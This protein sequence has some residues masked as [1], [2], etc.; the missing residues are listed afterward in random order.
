M[1]RIVCLLAAIQS[2]A[3]APA[4]LVD[5]RNAGDPI[6]R[7]E[8][9]ASVDKESTTLSGEVKLTITI[10]ATGPLSVT[11]PKPLVTKPNLWRVR[12]DSPPLR[13]VADGREKWIQ[14]YRLSPLVRGKTELPLGTFQ[15]QAGGEKEMTI[16]WN[17]QSLFVD[18]GVLKSI[19]PY[20]ASPSAEALRKAADIEQLPPPP[21]I[22]PDSSPWLFAIVPILLLVA[23]VGVYLGRRKRTPPVPRDAVWARNE[24]AHPNLTAD[25][26]AVVMR[27]YLAYRFG[28][29]AEARTTPELA[30]TLQ[31]DGRMSI[32][33]VHEWRLLLDECDAVRF[34]G[35]G[36]EMSDIFQ[37]AGW[38]VTAAE[39]SLSA[40]PSNKQPAQ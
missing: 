17:E 28:L 24:L 32:D 1:I 11:Q 40:T 36:P 10:D 38:L 3:A 12:E 27:Q 22:E 13:E 31:V 15:V 30:T 19:E 20:V 23:G 18:I 35:T 33:S 29:P 4:P 37:R 21:T 5:I 6:K 14:T 7:I 39:K 34:S 16:N 26:C 9:R 25:R 2:L 8:A